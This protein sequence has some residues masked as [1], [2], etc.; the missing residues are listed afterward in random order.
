M[1]ETLIFT[2]A[3]MISEVLAVEQYLTNKWA[4]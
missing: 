4:I 3:V 1:G 2:R